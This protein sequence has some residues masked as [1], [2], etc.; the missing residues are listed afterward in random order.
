M[1]FKKIFD[2]P[3]DIQDIKAILLAQKGKLDLARVKSEATDLLTDESGK[4]LEALLA[5]Y[6]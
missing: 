1:I 4:Q 3:K 2:R 6:G 5:Q